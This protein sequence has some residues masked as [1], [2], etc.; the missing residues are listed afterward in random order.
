[1]RARKYE[2]DDS[3][4][5]CAVPEDIQDHS[6]D[7][8]RRRNRVAE[9]E[10]RGR[11]EKKERR[12][13]GDRK[14][15]KRQDNNDR[16]N[17]ADEYRL[18]RPLEPLAAG[19][20]EPMDSPK[21]GAYPTM[22]SRFG[23]LGGILDEDDRGLRKKDRDADSEGEDRRSRENRERAARK[24][25]RDRD[26]RD[27]GKRRD[28]CHDYQ[29][30]YPRPMAPLACGDHSPLSP[31]GGWPQAASPRGGSSPSSP[32][33][34]RDRTLVRQARPLAVQA[35]PG[36]SE[37][38]SP[39]AGSSP[40]SPRD[41][42]D[43]GMVR[44]GE[45]A[46]AQAWPGQS[47]AFSPR[48]GSSSPSSPRDQRDRGMV[49][50][51]KP[52]TTQPGQSQAREKKGWTLW[53]YKG[54]GSGTLPPP[55]CAAILEAQKAQAAEAKLRMKVARLREKSKPK[56]KRPPAPDAEVVRNHLMLRAVL[57]AHERG[58]GA[59]HCLMASDSIAWCGALLGQVADS[60]FLTEQGRKYY[61]E[62]LEEFRKGAAEL[63]T[64][65]EFSGQGSRR[66][67]L[68]PR[69]LSLRKR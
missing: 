49:R 11:R 32:R 42:R 29:Y 62:L 64:P 34:R 43:R 22:K 36:L 33:D 37:A 41:L 10:R 38:A 5:S 17:V 40:S 13:R 2:C 59:M 58:E 24:T 3:D 39:R 56:P 47:E 65:A 46:A 66:P 67:S 63:P 44:N 57:S 45:H 8:D 15:G 4:S 20:H 68:I 50:N 48:G 6:H 26:N 12:D 14:Q 21:D 19:A 54:R 16:R 60:P 28:N 30:C 1:M 52:P 31:L 55:D 7:G 53:T 18:P 27:Q 23:D 61:D 69:A 9:N 51:V 25:K 35:W